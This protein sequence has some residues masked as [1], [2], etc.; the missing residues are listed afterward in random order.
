MEIW[1]QWRLPHLLNVHLK[2]KRKRMQPGEGYTAWVVVPDSRPARLNRS[3]ATVVWLLCSESKAFQPRSAIGAAGTEEGVGT[4]AA[5]PGR[6]RLKDGTA[7]S[8]GWMDLP[9][10]QM[11]GWEDWG[12]GLAKEDP[13]FQTGEGISNPACFTFSRITTA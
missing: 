2:K 3:G 11:K 7:L 4:V 12:W 6:L 13:V 10:H 1:E 8:G 5:P 9:T